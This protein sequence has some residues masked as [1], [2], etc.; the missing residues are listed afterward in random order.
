VTPRGGK[1]LFPWSDA[2]ENRPNTAVIYLR[3]STARQARTGG[4]A[5]GYSI[6]AQRR[7]CHAKA[8]QLGLEVIE[9]FVD[10]GASARSADRP[11]LQL[12]LTRLRDRRDVGYVIIHK[13]DRLARNR[14]DDVQIGLAIHSAGA[15]LV[16]CS[17]QIDRTP[18]GMLVHGIMA[19]V[20]EFYSANLSYEA[21]KGLHEKARRGGTPTYAPLG[22]LNSRQLVDGR[23]VKTIT[24][25]PDRAP[26][27]RWAFEAYA[28]GD[29]SITDLVHELA[30]RG[31]KT[32]PTETRPAVPLTRSQVHRILSNA[33]Y[34]GK[35]IFRGA[36]EYDG[37]HPALIDRKL[38]ERVQDVLSGR[39]I[40]GDRSWR[41]EHYL[42][43]TLICARCG[44]RLGLSRSRGKT[45]RYYFYFFCLGRNKRRTTCD[46]PYL[47]AELVEE[48]VMRH[49][50]TV[51]LTAELIAAVR[52][53][54][55][56]EMASKRSEDEKLLVIQRRRLKR[57]D[58]QRQKLIDA[59]LAEAIP[60]A[61][62]KRRQE[63]LAAEQRDAERLIELASINHA[64]LEERLE[65]A[66]GLLAACDHLY[67]GADE[68][69]RRALNQ[70]FF[71]ALE[72]DEDRVQSA[73]LNPP[74]AELSDRSIGLSSDGEELEGAGLV[75]DVGGAQNKK[76]KSANPDASRRRGS[77][78]TLM[79]EKEGFEPSKEVC[80]PLTP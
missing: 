67:V 1:K 51:A 76:P 15:V 20:S 40:A 69:S 11:A 62:L 68:T 17:E 37:N 33:Y 30:R 24:I 42:K 73:I 56:D 3:V 19:S 36:F 80:T 27:V 18:T 52:A 21:K 8:E 4:E 60:V 77:N 74:F 25:D 79:A 12:L 2:D 46:L 63:I 5:E 14:I 75:P 38:W 70:A 71:E 59:Y 65:I 57:I 61:E 39:R 55:G 13:I 6:P 26:H 7:A 58:R 34:T 72:I 35:I 64:I 16:S 43:G 28:T 44:S 53:S 66:L 78:L 48:N 10:A 22:Y 31:M 49:W 29:W 32:R 45:G 50:R 23:E 47:P 54:V 41:H 9:E